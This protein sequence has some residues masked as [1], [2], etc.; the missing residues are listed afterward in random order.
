M[1]HCAD[2]RSRLAAIQA[3]KIVH[4]PIISTPKLLVATRNAGKLRELTQLLGDVPCDLVSLDDV[5][6]DHEVDETGATFD[7]NAALKAETYCRLSGIITL[8]DDSGLE[9]DAL[10]GEPGIRS[11]RYAGPDVSDADRVAFLL[12]K[13]ADT[14]P[15]TWSARFRCS[16]AIAAPGEDVELHSG[17]CE[18]RIVPKP[19]GKNGF[20][21]DP[22]F[23]FPNMGLTMAELPTRLKNALSHRALAAQSAVKSLSARFVSSRP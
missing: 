16:I 19:R 8:A 21:Y 2:F 5:G 4:M 23:E 1:V 3:R 20:G 17:A 10:G 15:D 7:E 18:G 13:L 12:A 11:A 9:V 22:I 14:S 6:I